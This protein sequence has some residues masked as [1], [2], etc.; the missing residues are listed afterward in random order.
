[1]KSSFP[2][3]VEITVLKFRKFNPRSDVKHSSWFRLEHSI[4]DDPD[5]FDFTH[6]EF[7]AWIYIMAQASKK[8][9]ETIVINTNHSQAVSRIK[10]EEMFSALEK[11]EQLQCITVHV[12]RTLRPRYAHV[13]STNATNGRTDETNERTLT[14]DLPTFCAED[15]LEL[16]NES[17]GGLPKAKLSQKRKDHVKTRIAENPHKDYWEEVIKRIAKSDFC[18][19]KSQSSKGWV[20]DFDWLIKPDTHLKVI[21]GKYDNRSNGKSDEERI[22]HLMEIC[23]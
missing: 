11:L 1:M 6:G 21:E 10:N 7:K 18:N 8:N 20:A 9:T 16:W 17:C 23:Q 14:C 15:L 5:F 2:T 3:S 22:R 13:T 12:T 19:N 4:I